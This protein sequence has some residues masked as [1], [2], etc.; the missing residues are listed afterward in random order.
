[1]NRE[2]A[3]IFLRGLVNGQVTEAGQAAFSAWLEQAPEE[4]LRYIIDL[5]SRLSEAMQAGKDDRLRALIEARLDEE[6]AATSTVPARRIPWRR[7]MAAA[8]LLILAGTGLLWWINSLR[9]TPTALVS[10]FKNDIAP[11]GNKATLT[12]GNGSVIILDSAHVGELFTQGKTKIIKQDSGR[13]A[14]KPVAGISVEVSY[15]TLTTPR[16]GQYQLMLPDGSMVWLNAASSIRYPT[17]FTGNR[18]EVEINGEA[19]FEIAK[20]PRK[21]FI[22]NVAGNASV[23]VL[24]THFNINAYNDE[25][26][27]RTTLLEGS[28]KMFML[29]AKDQQVILTPGDQALFDMHDKEIKTIKNADIEQAVAWKNGRFQFKSADIESLMRQV[30]RWYDIEVLY[31][32]VKTNDRFSGKISRSATL[33]ELLQILAT[34]HVHFKLEGRTLTVLP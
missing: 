22:V 30:A 1:M 9:S 11:G 21:P 25:A 19:Y 15:N 20:D 24:G 34:S 23:E 26:F 5:H 28:I 29:Q 17:V 8:V 10:T 6:T 14:Y 2:E 13:I 27:V 31:T 32:G 4:D 12:L 18:R 16:G 3:A 7:W 33:T